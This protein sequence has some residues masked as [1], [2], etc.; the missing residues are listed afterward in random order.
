MQV[1][2]VQYYTTMVPWEE[3]KK[4]TTIEQVTF[5]IA[6]VDD[7]R[8]FVIVLFSMTDAASFTFA[9]Q[10]V[11]DLLQQTRINQHR[12]IAVYGNMMDLQS[13]IVVNEEHVKLWCDSLQPKLP[14]HVTVHC[15]LISLQTQNLQTLWSRIDQDLLKHYILEDNQVQKH[16]ATMKCGTVKLTHL[17]ANELIH[18]FSFLDF[19]EFLPCTL[20][21][22]KNVSICKLTQVEQYWYHLCMN[23]GLESKTSDTW[24]SSFLAHFAL[25]C[26]LR[27]AA[28]E[29]AWLELY[30]IVQPTCNNSIPHAVD[31]IAAQIPEAICKQMDRLR[32]KALLMK[33]RF[34]SYVATCSMPIINIQFMVEKTKSKPY[35]MF[36][37]FGAGFA[38]QTLPAIPLP[39]S[40]QPLI[41]LVC[42]SS[43]ELHI[44]GIQLHHGTWK[45]QQSIHN[46]FRD[47]LK[48]AR[49]VRT[50]KHTNQVESSLFSRVNP[51]KTPKIIYTKQSKEIEYRT[52]GTPHLF[53]IHIYTE[54]HASQIPVIRLPSAHYNEVKSYPLVMRNVPNFGH[55]C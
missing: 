35:P 36:T 6:Q 50:A 45:L 22:W 55:G 16:M 54:R 30:A 23:S 15:E 3:Q 5:K 49:L 33:Q 51:L 39:N 46:I 4:F 41:T 53:N 32:E 34:A 38:P 42:D 20:R 47:L 31:L 1:H 14:F 19:F 17:S 10:A 9:Q 13:A 40:M 2:T 52:L 48:V 21:C 12:H 26:P 11:D 24:K 28:Y 37:C 18:V 8:E 25:G 43:N 44:Y 7:A 29:K 27:F